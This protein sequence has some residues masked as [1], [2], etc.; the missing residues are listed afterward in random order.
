MSYELQSGP[1]IIPLS[2][3]NVGLL[4]GSQQ[5][6]NNGCVY[7]VRDI[8]DSNI[9]IDKTITIYKHA[10]AADTSYTFEAPA[11]TNGKVCVFWLWINM[12]ATAY[13]IEFP[14]SVEWLSE[15]SLDANSETLLVFMSVDDGSTWTAN[16]QL[17]KVAA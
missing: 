14:A 13:Q 2:A 11:D 12:G 15:P 10:P 5:A 17:E 6:L 4:G 16:V 9:S 1:V 3:Y 8:S 7:E